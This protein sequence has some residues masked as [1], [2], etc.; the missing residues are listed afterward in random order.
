MGFFFFNSVYVR[1]R[2]F[3]VCFFIILHVFFK[4]NKFLFC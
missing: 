1:V 2:A 4:T 3:T